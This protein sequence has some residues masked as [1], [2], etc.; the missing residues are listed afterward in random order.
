MDYQVLS[1]VIIGLTAAFLIIRPIQLANSKKRAEER[2]ILAKKY[3]KFDGHT[4]I[5]AFLILLAIIYI[6]VGICSIAEGASKLAEYREQLTDSEELGE[7]MTEVY[8]DLSER[9][10][11]RIARD[12]YMVVCSICLI[13]AE[14]TGVL[15][16]G[17]YVTSDGVMWFGAAKPEKQTLVRAE[18]GAYSFYVGKKRRYAFCLPLSEENERLFAEFIEPPSDVIAEDIS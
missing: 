4:A 12:R 2:G 1:F 3:P 17:A 15:T 16:Q 5:G 8:E 10:Q 13:V 7:R 14:L 6:I 18:N 9:E 11:N